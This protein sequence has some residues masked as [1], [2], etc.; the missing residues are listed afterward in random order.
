M[1]TVAEKVNSSIDSFSPASRRIARALL[2]DYPSAGLGTTS[3]LADLANS[4]SASV[5]RFCTQLGFD[6]FV[7]LQNHLRTELT[8]RSA[9]PL[10]RAEAETAG[11][12]F[13]DEFSSSGMDRANLITRTFQQNPRSEI[14]RLVQMLTKVSNRVVVVGGHYS[15]L[16]GRVAQLQLSKVRPGVSFLED[17][18]GRDLHV[19]TDLRRKDVLLVLDVR[20]YQEHLLLV[21]EAAKRNSASVALITDQWLSPVA[22]IADVVLQAAVDV[23]FFDSQV[24]CLALVEA[25]VHEAATKIEGALERLRALEELRPSQRSK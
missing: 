7:E 4:S 25:V 3:S 11:R 5:V 18:M 23:S 13:S 2:A 12:D 20:R 21:S 24:G 8:T 6:S 17:P 15:G 9:S 22:G 16:V 19:V 14:D 10:I 1:E